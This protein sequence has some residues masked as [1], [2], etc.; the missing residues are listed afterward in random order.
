MFPVAHGV[1]AASD[2]R[3]TGA[4]NSVIGHWGNWSGLP[5]TSCTACDRTNY[6]NNGSGAGPDV[7]P[8]TIFAY[9]MSL[10]NDSQVSAY[11]GHIKNIYVNVN[12]PY[13]PAPGQ[14]G[15]GD[16]RTQE[17]GYWMILNSSSSSS[18][19][20]GSGQ[21]N[22]IDD[23]PNTQWRAQT[24][25][26]AG[27]GV[28]NVTESSQPYTHTTDGQS[29]RFDLFCATSPCS[30]G[31]THTYNPSYGTNAATDGANSI[32]NDLMAELDS[33]GVN[34]SQ[35]LEFGVDQSLCTANC[36]TGSDQYTRFRYAM[37]CDFKDTGLWRVWD[38]NSEWVATTHNCVAFTP[39]QFVHF[40][41]HYTRPDLG[42]VQ[43]TDFMINGVTYD[44]NMTQAAQPLGTAV[45]HE[46][47]PWVNEIRFLKP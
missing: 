34:G 30:Y 6:L 24:V 20:G 21:L 32:T 11:I 35:A 44:V 14:R 22:A 33:V 16:W 9:G 43:Y 2:S 7:F 26:D 13:E 5:W 12:P 37:Q 3:A 27:F 39:L 46:F 40:V 42:H 25:N 19:G 18:G 38:A 17:N 4:Y 15:S 31:Y 1:V 45:T 28:A 41:F 8:W 47:I 23:T 36:G 10:Q 29:I